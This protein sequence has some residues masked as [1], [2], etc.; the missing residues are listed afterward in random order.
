MIALGKWVDQSAGLS[1]HLSDAARAERAVADRASAH[2][3]VTSLAAGAMVLAT[4]AGIFLM[5]YVRVTR[6]LMRAIGFTRQVSDGDL[7]QKLASADA[8]QAAPLFDALADMNSSLHRIVADVRT[9]T[10]TLADAAERIND[11]NAELTQRT[12]EH[13]TTLEEI[14][15]SMESLTE[16]VRENTGR[17]GEA[18]ALAGE[19]SRHAEQGS[20]AVKGSVQTM[21]RIQ[22]SSTRIYEIV[23][24]ID[25]IAF[26][27][28]ILALN[29]AVE[30]ARAGEHGRGFAVVAGEVRT[31]AQRTAV[32]AKDIKG[33]IADSTAK[34]ETGAAEA[35]RIG[36]TID[37]IV[38]SFGRLAGQVAEIAKLSAEQTGGI[39]Q[40]NTALVQMN[41]VTQANAGLVERTRDASDELEAQSRTLLAAIARF[42]IGQPGAPRE[43]AAADP[44][45]ALRP[46]ARLV[47][48][49]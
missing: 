15:A 37:A 27:T 21:K 7:T 32:A 33:L 30:A 12:E 46:V 24:L 13:A 36:E 39:E 11:W 31:L 42:R 20:A 34:V 16:M 35:A 22:D 41:S 48:S 10:T 5:F 3:R 17:A 25:G 18:A 2:A 43:S 49:A 29:A 1:Q 26:Q 47:A 14:T 9:G 45:L 40:I 6:P 38:G 4:V 44:R 19:A 8:G 23:A 28:N